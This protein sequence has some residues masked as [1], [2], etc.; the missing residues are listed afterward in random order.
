MKN[1]S[2]R[3]FIKISAAGTASL[4]LSGILLDATPKIADFFDKDPL[5]ESDA[6]RTPTYCEVCFWKCAGWV[7]KNRKGNIQKIIGNDN[8]LESHG[9]MCPRG[10]GGVGFYYDED[11]LKK[12]MIRVTDAA[13]NQSYKEVSWDEA[14]D[15]TANKLSEIKDQFGP[16]SIALFTHG[17]A[18]KFWSH[19]LNSIGSVSVAAPSY[20]QCRGPREVAFLTTFGVGMNSPEPTDIEN[21]KCLVLIGA[22][23][24]ENMHNGQ[25]Q[26]MSTLL[27]RGGTVITV[28]PRFSTAASKSKYWLPIK[29]ATDLALL[30]AWIHIIINEE[31]YDK[32]YIE[33]YAYGFEQLKQHVQKY[34]PEWAASETE[35]DVN[36]IKNT[37]HEM[38][39]AA[40]AVI[41][42]PGRHVTW[43]G[44][45]TQ[46]LRAVAILNALLGSFGRKGGFYFVS[47]A[48]APSFPH[49]AYPQP[50]K[51]WK[52]MLDGKYKLA[53]LALASGICDATVPDATGQIKYKAWI[54]NGTNLIQTLPNK[55]N[56]LKAINELDLL[57]VSDTM[58]TEITG[59]ADVILPECTYLERYDMPRVSQGRYPTIALR[60]PAAKPKYETKPGGGLLNKLVPE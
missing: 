21:S 54:V 55:A 4:A 31:L 53:G 15:F 24:G 20:A 22:H 18:G 34:T 47:K 35:L 37:A 40:P 33:R 10:T 39:K 5:I 46:R 29:P 12:P 41:V 50:S 7:Y 56:T 42:H 58:P 26:E 48:K 23:I 14:L 19:M 9:R 32:D 28:D 49:K 1:I 8:D 60:M 2:R 57:I 27:D 44:D 52:D 17:S 51:T 25:V 38:A 36:L 30:L 11:R 3:K 45:D 16:E 13:G 6:E 59:Y 43:Y